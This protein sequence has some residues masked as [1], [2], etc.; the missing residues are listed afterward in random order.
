MP[1][2]LFALPIPLFIG[3]G[4][5]QLDRADQ[6]RELARTMTE[7]TEMPAEELTGM[8]R[9]FAALDYRKLMARG[10]FEADGQIYLENRREGG[11]TGFHVIT[12][13]HLEGSDVRVLVNRGWIPAERD[14]SPSHAPAASG[15]VTVNGDAYVPSAPALVL[16]GGAQAV[17]SWGKRWPYLTIP[18]FAGQATYPVE[19]VM[20]LQSPHDPNGFVR[21][22]PRDL[23]GPGMHIGYAIQWFAFAAIAFVLYLRLSLV[24]GEAQEDAA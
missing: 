11:R 7:R 4:Y 2:L 19:P 17:A 6:K 18:L 15:V 10:T 20:I 8:V 14:G 1:T 13:L 5:W 23:P 12:P 24:S 3:L 16:G 9:D 21:H 22:W